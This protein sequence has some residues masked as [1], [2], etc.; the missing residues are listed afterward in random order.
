MRP[1]RRAA[2]GALAAATFAGLTLQ[3]PAAGARTAVAGLDPI[4]FVHGWNSS[5]STWNT[6]AGR[7]QADGWA[8]SRLSQWSYNTSQS[9]VTT[10]SQLAQ[11]I[12][13]V[14][15]AT[16]AA[17]VDVVTHSMGGL[18]SRYYTKNLGGSAKVDSWVSLGGPNHGTDTA[19]WCGGASCTEMRPGS[20]FLNALNSGDETPGTSRYATWWSPCD[21]IINPESSVAL[22]GATNTR[23]ACLGH[24]DLHNDAT[25]YDQV[26][27][28]VG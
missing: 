27:A 19:Y 24:S 18:S 22:S 14:L 23:T 4:V 9:N 12:D 3:A 16:G 7:F 20:S 25:V 2:A 21:S 13:R 5:G 10:A 11:E 26:K 6:M 17:R 28:F 8:A 15:A 1:S